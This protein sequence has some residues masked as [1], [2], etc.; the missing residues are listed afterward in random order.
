[1]PATSGWRK[2]FGQLMSSSDMEARRNVG[3]MT[4]AFSPYCELTIGQNLELHAQLYHLVPEKVA[5]RIDDLLE[6]KRRHRPA[7]QPLDIKQ[8]VRGVA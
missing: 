3:Y 8:R 5:D 6:E 7:G 4:Q 1:L 2:L